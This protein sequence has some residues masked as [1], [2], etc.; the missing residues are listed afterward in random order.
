VD[1]N[2]LQSRTISE[3]DS[4]PN[5]PISD[6]FSYE[7]ECPICHIFIRDNFQRQ[8]HTA[9]SIRE[10]ISAVMRYR[11]TP[12]SYAMRDYV[13]TPSCFTNL[14]FSSRSRMHILTHSPQ[15]RVFE[16]SLKYVMYLGSKY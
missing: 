1:L 5:P 16:I 7:A 15:R 6:P 3:V 14:K 11:S 13:S 12:L 4:V 2:D 8:H 9:C 10:L